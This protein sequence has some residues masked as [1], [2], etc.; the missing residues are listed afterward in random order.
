MFER[1]NQLI[2]NEIKDRN[3]NFKCNISPSGLELTCDQDLIEQ[4]LLNILQNAFYALKLVSNPKIEMTAKLGRR[5]QIFIE[6]SDNGIGIPNEVQEKIFIPFFTTKEGG[7]GI[8]LSLSQQIMRQHK[9]IISVHS[10]TN[11]KTCF[12]LRF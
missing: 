12:T 7:S 1:V 4:V 8:G 10:E 9:G 5:G 3:I 2:A 11:Q 6:I